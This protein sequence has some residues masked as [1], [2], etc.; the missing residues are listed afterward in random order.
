[1]ANKQETSQDASKFDFGAY[2]EDTLFHERRTN[3][4]RREPEKLDGVAGARKRRAKKERRRRVEPTTLEKQFTP[5]ELEFM[6]A[7]QA[8]K[9]HTGRAFPTHVEVLKVAVG[10]GYRKAVEVAP[11]GEN[12]QS[13]PANG[14]G[15][16]TELA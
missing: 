5:D 4:G 9:V 3:P 1:M 11:C 6:N 16:G 12:E 10:L 14:D 2:P 15:T 7:M 13:K 8:F